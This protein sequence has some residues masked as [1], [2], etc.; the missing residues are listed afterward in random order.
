MTGPTFIGLSPGIP[1]VGT[2]GMKEVGGM[3]LE[4]LTQTR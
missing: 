3:P 1:R 4:T 2:V